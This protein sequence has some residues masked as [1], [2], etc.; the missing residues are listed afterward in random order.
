M[1]RYNRIFG[2]ITVCNWIKNK[3]MY[4]VADETRASKERKRKIKRI[5]AGAFQINVSDSDIP[6]SWQNASLYGGEKPSLW[7]KQLDAANKVQISVRVGL[8]ELRKWTEKKN[9]GDCKAAEQQT[10]ISYVFYRNPPVL[11]V[12][13][14]AVSL[15]GSCLRGVSGFAVCNEERDPQ[16]GHLKLLSFFI[17]IKREATYSYLPHK[18]TVHIHRTKT[19]YY[20]CFKYNTC[21]EEWRHLCY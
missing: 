14:L 20:F 13:Q 8:A 16:Y 5:R 1:D 15:V 18:A 19:Y 17:R 3:M 11:W 4:I 7:F 6:Q 2:V 12:S 10:L 21:P 9:K